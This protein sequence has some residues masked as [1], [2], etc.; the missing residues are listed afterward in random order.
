VSLPD[1]FW[2]KVERGPECWAWAGSR[3]DGYGRFSLGGRPQ[4]AHRLAWEALR[5]PI[6]D[7]MTIDH[8]CRNRACVNPDHMEVVTPEEN[9]RRGA[10]NRPRHCPAGH[11]YAPENTRIDTRGARRC[12]ECHRA[13]ERERAKTRTNTRVR[14]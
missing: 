7:G 8:L 13:R 4:R 5:A 1:R 14:P 3:S 6:P 11:A 9:T 12:R 2:S 10:A